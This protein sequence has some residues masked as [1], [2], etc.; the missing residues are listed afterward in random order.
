M[1]HARASAQ[2]NGMFEAFVKTL[3]RDYIRI[4]P[5]PD[6]DTA[7]RKIDG[8]IEDYNEIHPHSALK[9]ASPRE[10]IKALSQ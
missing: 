6:A 3:K 9:M 1:L 10:F 4:S 5:I 2:S 8:W 7:L